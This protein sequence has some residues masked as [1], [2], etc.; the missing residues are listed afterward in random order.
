VLAG[1]TLAVYAQVRDFEFVAFDDL[2]C[3][4]E[5]DVVGRGLDWEGTVAVFTG[6]VCE[7]YT[8]LAWLSHMLDVELYGADPAGH[9]LGSVA[10]HVLST[11]LLFG[12]LRDQTG[13]VFRSAAVAA[14][15]A[16]H[17]LHVESVAWVAERRDVLSGVLGI[18]SLW[19]YC[20]W[21]RGG[22][23]AA[24]GAAFA[25]LLLGL[26]S[27][28][29]LVT[30]PLLFLLLDD[31][32]LG[33]SRPLGP[34][35]REK[36]PFLLLVAA[37]AAT[38]LWTQGGGGNVIRAGALGLEARVG[39]A[40]VSYAIYLIRTVWPLDLA[41][42]YPHPNLPGGRGP[43]TPGEIA[44]AAAL[45]LGVT[46]GVWRLRRERYLVVGWLWYGI[47]LA[48]VIGLLQTGR[49]ALADRYT[50]LP[51][52]G[53]FVAAV[54]GGHALLLARS[55]GRL[56]PARAGAGVAL[57]AIALLSA[58]SW[59]QVG[60]WRDS[61]ALFGRAAEVTR[62]NFVAHFNLGNL[63]KERGDFEL[64]RQHYERALEIHPTLV[65]AHYNLAN[66]LR[67]RKLLDEAID[68]YWQAALHGRGAGIE[69]LHAAS[70]ER[71]GSDDVVIDF[72]REFSRREPD[73]HEPRI[74]LGNVLRRN[75]RL[76]EAIASYR[77]ALALKPDD[78][79]AR[80][81]LDETLAQRAAAA[82]SGGTGFQ[83]LQ[84]D[85]KKS[86]VAP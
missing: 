38:T 47:A 33:R 25:C 64:A 34:R 10:L 72:L 30:W 69:A 85:V 26:L 41:V 86:M 84:P 65:R 74:A 61:F 82:P 35:I 55:R 66:L 7:N 6:P 80:G 28:P 21:A 52:I 45:L 37:F 20:R 48:P 2:P 83:D 62:G 11:L 17:P 43:W 49:A 56:W 18:G 19:S 81:R 63:H 67:E 70:W 24:F 8:P 68:H 9:H 32:P 29:M 27:K 4:V 31:W 3:V 78:E 73:D 77:E 71:D 22:G 23:A 39:N 75:G 60:T 36:L 79:T 44:A 54:W 50:Y 13:S 57:A 15:F 12:W 76:D 51:L 14:L 1:A 16:L 40:I 46:L 5:N 42:L 53:I 59:R 58:V